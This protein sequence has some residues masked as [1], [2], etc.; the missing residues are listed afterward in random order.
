MT[1][2]AFIG[3]DNIYMATIIT[4]SRSNQTTTD[5]VIAD[6]NTNNDSFNTDKIEAGTTDTL[7]NKTIV[8]GSNTITGVT[9]AMTSSASGSDAT[10]MTGT[11]GSTDEIA[12]FNVDG[13]VVTTGVSMTTVAPSASSDDTTVP[14]SEA[15][16]EAISSAVSGISGIGTIFLP[17]LREAASVTSTTTTDAYLN[18]NNLGLYQPHI[19]LSANQVAQTYLYLPTGLSSVTCKLICFDNAG[20]GTSHTVTLETALFV[21]GSGQP[22]AT[23]SSNA[24]AHTFTA[25]ELKYLDLSTGFPTTSGIYYLRAKTNTSILNAFGLE[26]TFNYS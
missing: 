11:A 10:F 16:H 5:Q 1:L 15:T 19:Q 18:A 25:S 17:F 6:I 22:S 3:G 2:M 7:T 23:S 26:I 12:K 4:M 20:T 14:T 13:D 21:D 9:P 24:V 8:A